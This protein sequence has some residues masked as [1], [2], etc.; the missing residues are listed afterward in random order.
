MF[1]IGDKVVCILEF[2]SLPNK[3]RHGDQPVIK[4]IYTIRG[5]DSNACFFK[6]EEIRVYYKCGRECGYIASKFRKVTKTKT[7]ISIFTEIVKHPDKD[8][9]DDGKHLDKRKVK[10]HVHER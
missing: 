2:Q 3:G 7:D 6:L 4:E 8:I 9:S 10:E 5:I 1:A